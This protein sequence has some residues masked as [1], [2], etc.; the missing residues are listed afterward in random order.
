MK[1]PSP[2]LKPIV[3]ALLSLA[4]SAASA[5][6]KEPMDIPESDSGKLSI[7]LK[8]WNANWDRKNVVTGLGGNY[9][10]EVFSDNRSTN[11]ITIIPTIQYK[12][13]DFAVS[14]STLL[15]KNLTGNAAHAHAYFSGGG[16]AAG[17]E[18]STS[19]QEYDINFSY[20][21]RPNVS[22][23]VGYKRV[24]FNDAYSYTVEGPTIGLSASAPLTEK[25]SLYANIG[26]GKMK[27]VEDGIMSITY[28]LIETG[29]AY[30][31]HDWV[32]NTAVTL[33][34]RQQE[35]KANASV[36]GSG[37][38]IDTTRGV[39]IGFTKSF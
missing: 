22:T 12:Y 1:H 11:G 14:L 4:A 19:R 8:F 20:F 39:A 21:F 36:N 34:Y 15:L 10:A 25:T 23:S 17:Y 7:G 28:G 9:P 16:T 18:Y 24:S 35:V 31:L 2:L 30:S 3:L 37:E 5:Q 29:V 33:S 26:L 27:L 6:T 38:I 32:K 13:N